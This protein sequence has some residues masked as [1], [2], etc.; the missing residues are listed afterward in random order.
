M[1]KF[2]IINT[3]LLSG[4]LFLIAGCSGPEQSANIPDCV[5]PPKTVVQRQVGAVIPGGATDIRRND[6]NTELSHPHLGFFAERWPVLALRA[7]MD[8][9]NDRVGPSAGRLVD[10]GRYGMPD[11]IRGVKGRVTDQF[12]FGEG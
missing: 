4:T 5:L 1:S 11:I 3:L 10:K 9:D 6:S 7:A 2:K 8:V 12:G